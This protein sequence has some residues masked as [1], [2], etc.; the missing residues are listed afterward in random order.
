LDS[1]SIHERLACIDGSAVVDQ[2]HGN[3]FAVTL[4]VDAARRAVS[5][6]A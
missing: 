1:L 5:S 2:Q 6:A 3:G 4:S